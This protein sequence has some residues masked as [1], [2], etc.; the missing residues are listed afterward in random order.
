MGDELVLKTATVLLLISIRSDS[1]TI[2]VKSQVSGV[3]QC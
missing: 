3:T 1:G 2:Q